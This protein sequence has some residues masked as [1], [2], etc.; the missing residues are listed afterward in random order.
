VSNSQQS[1][2]DVL[3][4]F[5]LEEEKPTAALV[6]EYRSRFPE[7]AD[8][9]TKFA[10]ELAVDALGLDVP[11]LDVETVAGPPSSVVMQSISNFQNARYQAEKEK[12]SND[13]EAF[14][15]A[16]SVVAITNP[17]SSLEPNQTNSGN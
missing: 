15:K 16:Q 4:W 6:D 14:S 12:R 5:S 2:S 9:I 7:Y 10:I 13:L 1:L 8:A 11:S 3:Y 17:F